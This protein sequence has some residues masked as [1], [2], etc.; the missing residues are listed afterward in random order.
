G[1][2]ETLR[3]KQEALSG[4]ERSRFLDVALAETHRL[5][6][7]VE[8]LFELAALDAREKQPTP[9]PFVAAEL[10]HDVV[11]KHQPEAGQAGVVLAIVEVAPVLVLADIAMTERVLDNLISNAIDHSP[12]GGTVN[13][14]VVVS[15]EGAEITVADAGPGIDTADIDHLFEPFYQASGSSRIGHAGLGLAIAQRMVSLQQGRLRVHNDNGAVFSV[16]LPLA[17]ETDDAADQKSTA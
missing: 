16:W 9:E 13:L 14:S 15:G 5:G 11:Q 7:L 10:L 4:D 12:E 6:R 3:L 2:L 17:I 1:Y 8:E